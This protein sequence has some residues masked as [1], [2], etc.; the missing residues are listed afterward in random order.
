M[1]RFTIGEHVVNQKLGPP[2]SG[3]ITGII[4]AKH[5]KSKVDN[6]SPSYPNWRAKFVVYVKL[7]VKLGDT[8]ELIFPEDDLIILEEI[9][10]ED[11]SNCGE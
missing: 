2:I 4:P 11:C 3:F 5:Y 10:N 1:C 9:F 6:W 8:E 7:D